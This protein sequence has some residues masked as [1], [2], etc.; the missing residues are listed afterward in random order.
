M[1]TEEQT[2][3]R[4]WL[5]NLT[6]AFHAIMTKHDMPEDIAI[7]I[8]AFVL[9]TARDQFRAGARSGAAFMREK[10]T[11]KKSGGYAPV[12]SPA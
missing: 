3:A 9:S 12:P 2:P 10:Y 5:S 4:R 7:E 11:G 6:D 1:S 8:E